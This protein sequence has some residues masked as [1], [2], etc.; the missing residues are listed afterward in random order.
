MIN[1]RNRKRYTYMQLFEHQLTFNINPCAFSLALSPDGKVLVTGGL[2]QHTIHIWDIQTGELINS[3]LAAPPLA[4][5]GIKDPIPSLAI[6]SDGSMLVT[7]G[8]F[9]KV[10]ELE[11]GKQIRVFKGSTSYTGYI[12]I[13]NDNTIL[14]TE[15]GGR[16]IGGQIIIWDFKRGK[17]IRSRLQTVAIKWVIS[18]DRKTVVGEDRCGDGVIKI[19]DLMTGAELRTLDNRHAIRVRELFFSPDGKILASS[20]FDGMKIWDYETGKQ[21][22]R[23]D[24]FK[25]VQF[26]QHLDNLHNIIFSPDGKNVLSSGSDGLIQIWDVSTGKNV[27][28]IQGKNRV[29]RIAMSSDARTLMGFDRNAQEESF[30]EVWKATT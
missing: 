2:H 20:G 8:G 13:S 19:W 11:T 23:V 9:L 26:H 12:N 17:K 1:I 5:Y 29:S 24:K 7:G 27:G 21:I 10:W 25:N 14:V 15:N 30:V 16:K 4:R 18:P 28:T 22:Q 6:T 3:W